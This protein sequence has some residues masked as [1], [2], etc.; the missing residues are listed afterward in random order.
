MKN[1]VSMKEDLKGAW[2][3]NKWQKLNIEVT[4]AFEIWQEAYKQGRADEAVLHEEDHSA[5]YGDVHAMDEGL[6]YHMCGY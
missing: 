5:M 6:A 4:P 2:K 1:K 3:D